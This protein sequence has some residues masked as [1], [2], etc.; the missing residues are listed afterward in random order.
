VEAESIA[1]KADAGSGS[2][3]NAG[4]DEGYRRRSYELW[5]RMA[6]RWERGREVLWATTRPASEWLIDRLSPEPGQTILELAAGAGE[7][8]FLAAD[9]LGDDGR[10]ICS[11]FAPRMV[12]AAERVAKE[13]GITNAE[14]RVLDAERLDFEDGSVD[15]VVCRFGYM[16]MADPGRALRETGRVLRD[17]GRLVFSVFGEPHRNPWMTV[18]RGVMV[19]RGHLQPADPG[20][21]GLFRLSDPEEIRSLLSEAG[22]VHGEVE[23]MPIAFRFD[24]AD[25]LWA[26]TSELQGPIAL[27]IAQLDD[28]ERE[29]VRAAIEEGCAAFRENGCYRLPGLV[30]NAL[31][32]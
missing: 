30:L 11:D 32:F 20:E 3:P 28:E 5:Q 31:A 8:G 18:A 25:R 19:E 22:F 15:G 1:A 12:E 23:E 24:D 27:A 2:V 14:F 9:R 13:L 17:R 29:A 10:L 4:A 26:Y 6:T 7:T 21:P 16:L